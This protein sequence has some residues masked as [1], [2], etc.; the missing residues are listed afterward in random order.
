MYADKLLRKNMDP[1][2][3]LQQVQV[4]T[5]LILTV[6]LKFNQDSRTVLSRKMVY[7]R[8]CISKTHS[9]AFFLKDPFRIPHICVFATLLYIVH[10]WPF[11][12]LLAYL[13]VSFPTVLARSVYYNKSL[14]ELKWLYW[15]DRRRWISEPLPPRGATGRSWTSGLA[16]WAPGKFCE[17]GGFSHGQSRNFPT[18][19]LCKEGGLS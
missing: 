7:F 10:R 8:L 15:W 5:M 13:Y 1:N 2:A 14:N 11:S 12:H 16:H 4:V 18:A 19:P 9:S 17:R 6:C 3:M